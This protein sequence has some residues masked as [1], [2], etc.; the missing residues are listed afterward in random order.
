MAILEN[1]AKAL[2]RFDKRLSMF[3]QTMPT[4]DA[5][6]EVMSR[7]NDG[8]I[9]SLSVTF[10]ERHNFMRQPLSNFRMHL[11]IMIRSASGETRKLVD[12]LI[13]GRGAR[14]RE[15]PSTVVGWD[16]I[17]EEDSEA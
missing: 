9:R 14:R 16:T 12:D 3:D 17:R 2:K 11:G 10:L 15:P 6:M 13:S 1:Y 4:R 8:A 7:T 5:L